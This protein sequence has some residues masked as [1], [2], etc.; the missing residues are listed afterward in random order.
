MTTAPAL[1]PAAIERLEMSARADL[2]TAVATISRLRDGSAH[3]VAGFTTWGEYLLAR[4]GDL[5][6]ELHLEPADRQ[7]VVLQL[8]LERLS[9]RAIAARLDVGLGTVSADIKALREAGRLGDE[10]TTVLSGDGRDRP[11]RGAS[12]ADS[13]APAASVLP[14]P[15]G[16]VYRQAAEWLRRADAGL[17]PGH[18]GLGLTLVELAAVAGWTEGKASG[19]LSY[20]LHPARQLAVRL[21]DERS[22]QRV[23]VLSDAGHELCASGAEE[24]AVSAVGEGFLQLAVS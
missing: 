9:Q 12:R 19:A 18:T 2:I 11:A 14:A 24:Q 5:L 4:F 23:H 7:D 22:S 10:P 21:E 6:A 17:I 8:R 16:L 13:E 3:A 1:S 20:L 15:A